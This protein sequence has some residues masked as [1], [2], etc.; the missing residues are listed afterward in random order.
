MMDEYQKRLSVERGTIPHEVVSLVLEQQITPVRAWRECLKL[1]QAEVA[2]RLGISQPSYA[3]QEDC[4]SLPRS[5]IDKIA[6]AL[7]ITFD[8]LDF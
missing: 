1:T 7:S 2:E 6:A 3:E 8:Q 4:E 5:S